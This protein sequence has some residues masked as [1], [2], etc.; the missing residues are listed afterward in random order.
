MTN[1][2]TTLSRERL[3]EMS[4]CSYVTT[5]S[6]YEM[7]HMA[8][9]LLEVM[10]ARAVFRVWPTK[11]D[12]CN[13]PVYTTPTAPS[14]PDGWRLVPVEPTDEM[15]TAGDVY[16]DGISQLL[17]AWAAMLEAAPKQEKVHE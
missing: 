6:A 10:D 16:M 13:V 4:Q 8:R 15:L 12:D 14:A 11:S 5:L 17:A 7:R 2:I 9:A 3:K 1:Q